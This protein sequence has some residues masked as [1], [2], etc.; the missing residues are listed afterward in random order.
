MPSNLSRRLFLAALAGAALPARARPALMLARDTD[1]RV[2]P[3]DFLVSEKFDG[4]RAVWD[5]GRMRFRSGLPVRAPD[6]FVARLPATPL[7]G[8]LWLRRGGF[9]ALS[10]IVRKTV[11]LDHEWRSVR[12]MVFDLP[13]DSGRFMQRAARLRG[14]AAAAGGSP[15][16]A[17]DQESLAGAVALRK[18]FDAVL[19]SGGEGLMLHRA[20]ALW[21]SG[22]SDDLLKLKPLLDAEAVV[23][24]HLPGS[25]RHA[26]RMGALRL[27]TPQG[28]EFSLGSGFSDAMRRS[29]PPLGASVSYRFRGTTASGLPRHA[30]FMRLDD[31]L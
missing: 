2:D 23:I 11:P 27:R 17:V 14:I 18:R 31:G 9:E 4:V 1:L 28:A 25:G 16:H 29:P 7:D 22:R 10:G 8:E 13:G 3:A 20:D 21:R 24:A 15:L 6:W 19:G 26:G 30:S 5:G 12:Y